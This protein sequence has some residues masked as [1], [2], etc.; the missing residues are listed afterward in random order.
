M[1]CGEDDVSWNTSRLMDW[2]TH[3]PAGFPHGPVLLILQI[4]G[5]HEVAEIDVGSREWDL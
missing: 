3:R 1:A 2:F 5:S 4:Q